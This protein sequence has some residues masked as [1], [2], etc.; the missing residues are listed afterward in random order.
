MNNKKSTFQKNAANVQA[1]KQFNEKNTFVDLKT[2][3]VVTPPS[4][5]HNAEAPTP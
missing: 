3:K 1:G 5:Q 4:T 2:G